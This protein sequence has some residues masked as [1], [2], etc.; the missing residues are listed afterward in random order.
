MSKTDATQ[1]SGPAIDTIGNHALG[2]IKEPAIKITQARQRHGRRDARFEPADFDGTSAVCSEPAE[3][4][5][6]RHRGIRAVDGGPD[7]GTF[8][9]GDKFRKKRS[10]HTTGK[11]APVYDQA[12]M[13][14]HVNET[15]GCGIG[16]VA[17]FQ[18]KESIT[19]RDR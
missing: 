8:G 4:S 6:G 12:L 9:F 2:A 5:I 3:R 17:S 11:I 1:N 10:A 19:R 18:R 16:A 7:A 14:Q 13:G 15:H